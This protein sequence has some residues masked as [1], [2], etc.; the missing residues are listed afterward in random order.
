MH[1]GRFV[2][3]I[4]PSYRILIV[5]LLHKCKFKEKSKTDK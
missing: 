2:A 4:L 3:Q 5:Q 1:K